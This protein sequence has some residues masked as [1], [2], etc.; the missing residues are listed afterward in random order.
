MT[1]TREM[2]E[3]DERHHLIMHE[4]DQRKLDMILEYVQDIPKM[5]ADI[6]EIKEDIK[7]IKKTLKRTAGPYTKAIASTKAA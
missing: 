5:R 7:D 1:R 4:Q 2:K 3:M 6:I